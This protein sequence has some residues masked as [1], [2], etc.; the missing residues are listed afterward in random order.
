MWKYF[1]REK[2]HTGLIVV[3][4]KFALDHDVEW[5]EEKG[6]KI[7]LDF[8]LTLIVFELNELLSTHA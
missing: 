8:I 2:A 3:E 7:G 1:H 5:L 6:V 4:L